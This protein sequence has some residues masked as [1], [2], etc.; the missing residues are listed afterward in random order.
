MER[1]EK[2]IEEKNVNILFIINSNQINRIIN[3]FI[4]FNIIIFIAFKKLLFIN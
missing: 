4:D 1:I 3:N 2:H